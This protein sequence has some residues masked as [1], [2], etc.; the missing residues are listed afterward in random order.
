ML[1]LAQ[2]RAHSPCVEGW[3]KLRQTVREALGSP[4]APISLTLG[5]SNDA[6]D[7]LWCLRCLPLDARAPLV[8]KAILPS[9][10]RGIDCPAA[11]NSVAQIER[12]LAG[13]NV[14]IDALSGVMSASS[15]KGFVAIQY[16]VR[17]ITDERLDWAARSRTA[18]YAAALAHE[19]DSDAEK[20]QVADLIAVF[21]QNL[22]AKKDRG[23]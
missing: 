10:K 12:W 16:L 14:D 2:I 17:F 23:M 21:G 6:T 15:P 1:T 22:P 5:A 13:E 7:A 3:V 11:K 4:D 20:A 9:I 18:A 8:V 19:Y